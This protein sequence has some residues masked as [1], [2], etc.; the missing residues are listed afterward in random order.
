M[1]PESLDNSTPEN[2]TSS[3]SLP[4]LAP[5]TNTL[6]RRT[7]TTLGLLRDVVQESS[8]KYWYELGREESIEERWKEAE[9]A[10][11]RCLNCDSKHWRAALQVTHTLA[12]LYQYEAAAFALQQAYYLPYLKSV[13]WRAELST[14]EWKSLRDSFEKYKV[15]VEDK[16]NVLLSLALVYTSAEIADYTLAR[17]TLDV[18]QLL[19]PLQVSQSSTWHILDGYVIQFENNDFKAAWKSL[20]RAINILPNVSNIYYKIAVIEEEWNINPYSERVE[21][22]GYAVVE[23]KKATELDSNHAFAHYKVAELLGTFRTY[24]DNYTLDEVLFYYNRT[25]EI[26]PNFVDAYIRRGSIQPNTDA[27]ILDFTKAI[28]LD[29][30]CAEAYLR[31]IGAYKAKKSEYKQLIGFS[32]NKIKYNNA[33]LNDFDQAID[34]SQDKLKSYK[35]KAEFYFEI[36]K[37]SEAISTLSCG[38][39]LGSGLDSEINSGY[40]LRGEWKYKSEDCTGAI[41]DFSKVIELDPE[42][43]YPYVYNSR[44]N[45]KAKIGDYI[46]AIA[47]FSKQIELNPKQLYSYRYRS[48]IKE[49]IGDFSGAAADMQKFKDIS[50]AKFSQR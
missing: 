42:M 49:K 3:T 6:I 25:I 34:L 30:K 13:D 11:N 47:D 18:L 1:A 8:A 27:S 35:L 19:Y 21:Y 12:R 24:N 29:P 28:E 16:F 7:Q 43:S 46:G 50:D 48:E 41:A 32:E 10:F 31:R 39:E 9:Y 38:L 17:Q 36:N 5:S 40:Y 15:M 23:Y 14:D 20:E 22:L 33:I 4:V 26:A 45:A 2:A 37:Y 44:A